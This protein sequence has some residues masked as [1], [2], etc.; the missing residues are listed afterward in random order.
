M[1]DP[2]YGKKIKCRVWRELK[3]GCPA[4]PMLFNAILEFLYRNALLDDSL[5][6]LPNFG[7]AVSGLQV[8][9][10][11]YADDTTLIADSGDSFKEMLSTFTY[12]FKR[13]EL[14]I[15]LDK[16]NYMA[17]KI[18]ME[19]S[20]E[21]PPCTSFNYL[22][23]ELSFLERRPFIRQIKVK[24]YKALSVIRPTLR[25]VLLK[26]RRFPFQSTIRSCYTYACQTWTLTKN[27]LYDIACLDRK[28]IFSC[29][30]N[31]CGGNS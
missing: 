25:V 31:K 19:N 30:L 17:F 29:K 9:G 14:N 12:H 6:P 5:N 7:V 24:G 2:E 23:R 13:V 18:E 4:S 20:F 15:N 26:A 1:F 3:Q 16:S 27:V 22:G 21:I 10:I 8:V 11:S 28:F